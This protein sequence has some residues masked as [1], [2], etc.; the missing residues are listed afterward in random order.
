MSPPV[1][2]LLVNTRSRWIVWNAATVA[3]PSSK[4]VTTKRTTRSVGHGASSQRR[5]RCTMRP[6]TRDTNDRLAR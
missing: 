3:P 2:V 5:G 1:G 6:P 4:V